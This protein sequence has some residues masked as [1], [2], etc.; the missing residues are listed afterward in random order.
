MIPIEIVSDNLSN[1]YKVF[2]TVI[3]DNNTFYQH[4][5][6]CWKNYKSGISK[7]VYSK[8]YEDIIEFRQFSFL[9]K[10]SSAIQAYYQYDDKGLKKIRLAYYPHPQTVNINQEE[11]ETYLDEALTDALEAHYILLHELMGQNISVSN[12]THLRFDFDRDVTSHSTNHMQIDGIQELRVPLQHV[13]TPFHF[14]DFI[15][16]H[17]FPEEYLVIKESQSFTYLSASSIKYRKEADR[18][19][20]Y[21]SFFISM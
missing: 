8:Q 17:V 5:E 4:K 7:M 21:S 15:V 19:A 13:V 16:R 18:E 9:L 14:L 6:V 11:I 3:I 20:G 2:R 12:S 10:D 1:S